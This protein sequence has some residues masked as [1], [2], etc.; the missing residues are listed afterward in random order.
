MLPGY[1]RDISLALQQEQEEM[2][3][4][5]EQLARGIDHIRDVV[6]MQQSYAGKAGVVTSVRISDLV[7]DAVRINGQKLERD[8]VTVVRELASLPKARLDRARVLQVLVNLIGNASEAL[9]ASP[10]EARRITV[11]AEAGC[12]ATACVCRCRT[13]ARASPP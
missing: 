12:A 5:L 9:R 7:E 2:I 8:D 10:P 1:L 4:E 11:R 6:T 13:R 3:A